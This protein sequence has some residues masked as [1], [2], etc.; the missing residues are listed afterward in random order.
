MGILFA[1]VSKRHTDLLSNLKVVMELQILYMPDQAW[2]KFMLSLT[3]MLDP[4]HLLMNGVLFGPDLNLYRQKAVFVLSLTKASA[5]WSWYLLVFFSYL[6][7]LH[8]SYFYIVP[9]AHPLFNFD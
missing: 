1:S 5:C 3:F 4:F 2:T 7:A 6:T 9:V 8:Y